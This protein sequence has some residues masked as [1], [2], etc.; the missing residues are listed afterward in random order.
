MQRFTRQWSRSCCHTVFNLQSTLHCLHCLSAPFPHTIT[1]KMDNYPESFGAGLRLAAGMLADSFVAWAFSMGLLDYPWQ[2]RPV[3]DDSQAQPWLCL[4]WEANSEE[5]PR[6]QGLLVLNLGIQPHKT[7]VNCSSK[8][9][10]ALQGNHS[11]NAIFSD[12]S[13]SLQMPIFNSY[14]PLACP[15]WSMLC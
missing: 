5:A 2:H 3:L 10:A 13:A 4:P 9:W 1:L 15:Q 12:L 7:G 6:K 14:R 11:L 8:L